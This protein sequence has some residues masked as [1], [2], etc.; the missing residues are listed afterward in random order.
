[1]EDTAQ[2]VEVRWSCAGSHWEGLSRCSVG[3]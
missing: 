3:W 1:V 2:E